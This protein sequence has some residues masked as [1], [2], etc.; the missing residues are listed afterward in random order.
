MVVQRLSDTVPDATTLNI[1]G[2]AIAGSGCV[3][4]KGSTPSVTVNEPGADGVDEP[5]VLGLGATGGN[6]SPEGG[7]I[8]SSQ[9]TSAAAPDSISQLLTGNH[10]D[11]MVRALGDVII[12]LRRR[13]NGA[14][15]V[16]ADTPCD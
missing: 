8:G 14:I 6:L 13:L 4:L 10:D 12:S 16:G 7:W 15:Y 11:L 9:A 5:D 3:A 2:S 1:I